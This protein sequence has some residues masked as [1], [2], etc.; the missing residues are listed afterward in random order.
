MLV[1]VAAAALFSALADA[2]GAML[3]MPG[4]GAPFMFG[5]GPRAFP[6]LNTPGVAAGA[7]AGAILATVEVGSWPAG[8]YER[9]DLGHG[10]SG[11]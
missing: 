5:T 10:R 4:V 8:V 7:G 6:N 3:A 9:A 1:F 11:Y 2:A